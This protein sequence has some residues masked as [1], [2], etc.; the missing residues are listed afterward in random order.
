MV[1]ITL[2]GAVHSLPSRL[3]E[4][5]VRQQLEYSRL[6]G[7]AIAQQVQAVE[8]IKNERH[9]EL[10]RN[11]LIIEVSE[12]FISFFAGIPLDQLRIM[13]DVRSCVTV[14]SDCIDAMQAEE[15]EH[16]NSASFPDVIT[17]D[18][19]VWHISTPE[20]TPA[21]AMTLNEFVHAKEIVRNLYEAG[22]GKWES[23]PYLCAVYMRHKDE[24][25]S[26]ALV[27]DGSPRL[28]QMK[29]LPLDVALR[30]AF[31]LTSTINILENIS[32]RL[33]T[34]KAQKARIQ[35]DISVNGD[36]SAS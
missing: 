5:T 9:K 34:V 10:E 32:V 27:A 7:E 31:F 24:P 13:A 29:A 14:Y 3:S 20:L 2:N 19:E 18:N 11:V 28:E 26:E 36:G 35:E 33:Q 21:S 30:V 23:L 6:H 16:R 8:A 15:D 22:N 1:Q 12:R 4:I 17:F 25:F